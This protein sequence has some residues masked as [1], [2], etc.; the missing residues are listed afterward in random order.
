MIPSLKLKTRNILINPRI[1]F[2]T[3][4]HFNEIYVRLDTPSM[5]RALFDKQQ[6]LFFEN[7]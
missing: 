1:F 7:V 2:I 6:K 5:P 4:R 3:C